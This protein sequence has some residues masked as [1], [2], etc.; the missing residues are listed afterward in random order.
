[1]R[2]I[3]RSCVVLGLLCQLG[4]PAA[5]AVN[6][7]TIPNPRPAGWAVDLTGTL[8]PASLAELND[9]GNQVNAKT[10]AGLA[11]VMVGSTDGVDSHTFA[12]RLFNTWRLG[13]R[14]V[15]VFAALTDHHAEIVLGD[16]LNSEATRRES[17]AVMQESIRPRFRA[18]DPTGAMV[19]GAHDCVRRILEVSPASAEAVGAAGAAGAK[20]LAGLTTASDAKPPLR[21]EPRTATSTDWAACSILIGILALGILLVVAVIQRL[22]A[23]RCPRCRATMKRLDEQED[24]AYL[25]P[26]EQAE[27][28]VKSVNYKVWVC[29]ACGEHETRK[30]SAFFS[31]FRIC[32]ECKA[33]TL[34][35]TSTTLTPASQFQCGSIEVHQACAN[36]SYR[37]SFNQTTPMLRASSSSSSSGPDSSGGG[38]SGS[39]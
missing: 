19:Q 24:D 6:V 9:L 37:N 25:Q 22:R 12:T 29:P 39:W 38:A 17:A 26:V 8:P 27:E 16:D 15:L 13:K 1:M 4:A 2:A 11:V 32:P 36:C 5:R 7:E 14:G 20:G 33:R 28:R 35:T 30:G 10:G 31:R 34:K 23:H 21:T 18:G 3:L